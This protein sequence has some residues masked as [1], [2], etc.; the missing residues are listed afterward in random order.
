MA[1]TRGLPIDAVVGRNLQ[2]IRKAKGLSQ[3]ALGDALGITFQQVQKYEKGTN[4]IST[5]TLFQLS[6][7]LGITLDAFFVGADEVTEELTH[8]SPRGQVQMA[9]NID[10]IQDPKIRRAVQGLVRLLSKE[11]G[12]A[13]R[14]DE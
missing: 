1:R 9:G 5:S 10:Q 12:N 14:L 11:D 4:R 2:N 3:S 6:R 8:P 7:M 13:E